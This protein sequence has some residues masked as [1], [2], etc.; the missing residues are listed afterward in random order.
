LN[1]VPLVQVPSIAEAGNVLMSL[2]AAQ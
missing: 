1:N 2:F